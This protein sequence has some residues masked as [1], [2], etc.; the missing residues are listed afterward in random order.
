MLE[1]REHL[2]HRG[3]GMAS[4]D[5]PTSRM[6]EG[7]D[8]TRFLVVDTESIPDG[9]LLNLVKYRD[10]HLS[11]EEAIARAFAARSRQR[12]TGER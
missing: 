2:L 10:A 5:S 1:G 4:F 3:T 8:A 9:R 7:D 6:N 11:P 12:L